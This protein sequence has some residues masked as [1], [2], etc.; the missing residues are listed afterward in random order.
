MQRNG[1]WYE[2]ITVEDWNDHTI[3]LPHYK[4]ILAL[5]DVDDLPE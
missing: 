2:V 1:A 5:R 3:G 4:Y